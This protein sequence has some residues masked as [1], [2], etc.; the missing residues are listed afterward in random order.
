MLYERRTKGR[1]N[2][3]LQQSKEFLSSA[4]DNLSKNRANAAGFNAIQAI[5]NANNAL[6]IHFLVEEQVKTIGKQYLSISM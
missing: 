1:A 6:T 4:I 5:I 2:N 3:S